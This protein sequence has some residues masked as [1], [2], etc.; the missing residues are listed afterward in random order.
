MLLTFPHWVRARSTS[1]GADRYLFWQLSK[2]RSSWGLGMQ[3]HDSLSRTI[4]QGTVEG[5][6]GCGQQRK[7]W[8]DDIKDWTSLPMPELLTKTYR[9]KGW[10]RISDGL[11]LM[12]PRKR[13]WSRNWTEVNWTQPVTVQWTSFTPP[14]KVNLVLAMQYFALIVPVSLVCEDAYLNNVEP[15]KKK[16]G[17]GRPH[18][19][20]V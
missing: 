11:S 9:R 13:N 16:R 12:W 1:L 3:C 10:K 19:S 14:Y 20:T 18:K 8:M 6:Q 2:D 7:C 4:L 17:G 5:R 15:V